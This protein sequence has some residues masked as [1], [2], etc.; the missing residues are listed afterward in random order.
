MNI[1]RINPWLSLVANVGVIAGF[2]FLA[3]EIRQNSE[4]TH[5]ELSSNVADEV[6]PVMDM[7]IDDSELVNEGS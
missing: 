7:L 2:I 4:M 5:L 6:S 1:D 3:V